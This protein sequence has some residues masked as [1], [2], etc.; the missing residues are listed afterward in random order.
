MIWGKRLNFYCSRRKEVLS[1]VFITKK[2]GTSR[3]PLSVYLKKRSISNFLNI[4]RK[5]GYYHRLLRVSQGKASRFVGIA[6][7]QFRQSKL[8]FFVSLFLPGVFFW[9][10]AFNLSQLDTD[11]IIIPN[12]DVFYYSSNEADGRRILA[13]NPV[14]EV[15]DILIIQFHQISFQSVGFINL[16]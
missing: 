15:L 5:K 13:H 4:G 2:R 7:Y 11:N 9:H 16:F 10:H 3:S 8:A 1:I 14:F 12:R 6:G